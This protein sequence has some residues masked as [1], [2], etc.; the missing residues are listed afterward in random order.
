MKVLMGNQ[1]LLT[2]WNP[3]FQFRRAPRP[4]SGEEK[5]VG[6]EGL[7]PMVNG[8]RVDSTNAITIFSCR[9]CMSWKIQSSTEIH[10]LKNRNRSKNFPSPNKNQQRRTPPK[11]VEPLP[12]LHNPNGACPLKKIGF[13]PEKLSLK[14]D[15]ENTWNFSALN[16][17]K[18]PIF[19]VICWGFVRSEI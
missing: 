6:C 16:I 12:V 4:T 19:F 8:L 15:P 1:A 9:F 5:L 17:S 14:L 11:V 10:L 18:P 13:F 3:A 2:S 7:R